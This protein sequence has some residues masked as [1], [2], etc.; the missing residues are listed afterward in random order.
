MVVKKFFRLNI[1]FWLPVV[2]AVGAVM[3]GNPGISAGADG[4]DPKPGPSVTAKVNN[5]PKISAAWRDPIAGRPVDVSNTPGI[6]INGNGFKN[7]RTR[8]TVYLEGRLVAEGGINVNSGAFQTLLPL[9][10]LLA[11]PRKLTV[12]V[13]DNFSQSVP[14]RLRRLHG[15]VRLLDGSAVQ[16]PLVTSGLYRRSDFFVTAIGDEKG[17]FEIL[18]PEQLVSISVFANNSSKTRLECRNY[19]ADL[20]EGPRLEVCMEPHLK[21]SPGH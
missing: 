13:G 6:M 10:S 9:K 4:K 1:V 15:T 2:L 8:I 21:F 12:S 7:G 11:D 18:V 19:D 5:N 3:A 16:F 17:K 20:K 14:V